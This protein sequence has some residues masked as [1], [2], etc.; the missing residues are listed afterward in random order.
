MRQHLYISIFQ[1]S[2]ELKI[3]IPPYEETMLVHPLMMLPQF[4]LLS[5]DSKCLALPIIPVC[6]LGR[7]NNRTRF[8]VEEMLFQLLAVCYI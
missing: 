6:L 2:Q 1:Y 8:Y 3:I 7:M 5:S 4:D